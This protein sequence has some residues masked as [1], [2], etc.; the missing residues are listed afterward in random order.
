[1]LRTEERSDPANADTDADT[2][3]DGVEVGTHGTFPIAMDTDRDGVRDDFEAVAHTITY[4]V[5]GVAITKTVKTDPMVWDTDR[6]GLSDGE[7][8]TLGVDRVVTNPVLADTDG[9]TLTDGAELMTYHS[10]ATLTDTDKDTIPDNLEV[11]PRTLTL[12][13]NGVAQSRYVTTLPN[14][15]D[16]DGDG[17][18]DDKEFDG[19][20]VY[21]V[22]TDPSDPDTDRDGLLDGQEKYSREFSMSTRK[23][24]GTSISEPLT[25]TISGPIE[26][27]DVRYGLSTIAVSNFY[28][29]ISRGSTTVVLRNHVGAGSYNY[30]SVDITNSFNPQGGQYT[31]YASSWSGGGVLEEFA[32]SFTLRTSPVMADSDGDGLNDSEETTYGADG[33]ITDPNRADTDGDG[34]SDGYETKTRGTNPLSID[35]DQDGVRD[36]MDIDPLRNLLVAVQVKQVHHGDAWWNPELAAVVRV[37]EGNAWVY[38]WV[39]AHRLGTDDGID[40][41]TSSFWMTYY[42]DVPDDVSGVSIRTTGWSINCCRGDDIIVDYGTTYWLNSGTLPFTGSSGSSWITFDVWTYAL[43]KAQAFLITDGNATVAASN[44]QQRLSGQDRYLVLTLDVTSPYGPFVYG[45]NSIVVPRSIFLQ[46]KLKADFDANS[47]W[48]L[49]DA[50]MYGED[51]GG[52]KDP[53][54]GVAGIIAKTLLGSDASNVLDR[55]LRNK[56]NVKVYSYVDVTSYGS[57]TNLPADVLR[58]LPWAGVTNGPTGEMPKGFWDKISG[59]AN[60]VINSLVRVGQLIYD[61]LIAISTFLANL[62]E[63]IWNFGMKV[64]GQV[65]NNAVAVAQRLGEAL[66]RFVDWFVQTAT[67][68]ITNA[69]SA[70]VNG[71]KTLFD[72]TIGRFIRELGQALSTVDTEELARRINSLMELVTLIAVAIALVPVAIRVASIALKAMSAG[73]SWLAE[74]AI[75]E[76]VAEFI[77]R[78]LMGIAFSL[79]LSAL[80][81]AVLNTVGWV[82]DTTSGFFKGLGI[83]AALI[84]AAAKVVFQVY[85]SVFRLTA[86]DIPVWQRYKG[87]AFALFGLVI[88][89]GGST[90]Y[91]RPGLGRLAADFAGLAFQIFGIWLYFRNHKD[92]MVIV[93][94]FVAPIGAK[95]EYGVT[96]FSPPVSAAKILATAGKGGYAQ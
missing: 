65:W 17:L 6:D 41:H 80:F 64:L 25:A 55:L 78:I 30:S 89:L 22:R 69:I 18:R 83:A 48:P 86:N 44:G 11:T 82:E 84:A 66:N 31:L 42:A 75:S 20:S 13:V 49:A 15:E 74:T 93:G 54:E 73:I 96:I 60:A 21:G 51:L 72:A 7:E 38:T 50:T 81:T 16:T 34:W 32:L 37:N 56:T 61:G 76:G 9:D 88:V 26:R 95:I 10:N 87:F 71:L 8:Y 58:I 40:D 1:M 53:S 35:T 57:V 63:A 52:T 46:S 62:G 36:N 24:V 68:V 85:R 92:P 77:V 23:I 94:D 91:A 14:R 59:A 39:T 47:N 43:P 79:A 45:I 70:L 2:L 12:T 33:W 28:V 3:R 29:Q 67:G 19:T 4:F 27:V 5:D 90:T